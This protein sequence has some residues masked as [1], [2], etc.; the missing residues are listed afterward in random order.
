MT[1]QEK[2]LKELYEIYESL[3]R[4]KVGKRDMIDGLLNRIAI[5]DDEEEVERH[6][7]TLMTY[8]IPD[9]VKHSR[10]THKAFNEY[11]DYWLKIKSV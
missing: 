11:H 1:E 3:H 9:Y 5:S 7:K 10:I 6:Y 4:T 8:S 2:K